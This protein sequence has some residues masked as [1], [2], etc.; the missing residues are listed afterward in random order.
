MRR[1]IVADPSRPSKLVKGVPRD[2][3]AICWKALRKDPGQRYPSARA[4]ADDLRR[5]IKSEPVKARPA[6]TLRR[7]AALGQAKQGLGGGT[8]VRNARLRSDVGGGPLVGKVYGRRGA[9]VAIAARAESNSMKTEQ[10]EG[11][12]TAATRGSDPA[13]ATAFACPISGTDGRGA[14][15]ELARRASAIQPDSRLQSEAATVLAGLDASKRQIV[16][17][18]R[19]G[20]CLRPQ[21]RGG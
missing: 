1:S 18:P 20:A 8:R 2:L 15:W 19:N 7:R 14:R 12:E 21:G 4:L 6:H 9:I 13:N 10:H 17:P 16:S 3:E 5:W 11:H